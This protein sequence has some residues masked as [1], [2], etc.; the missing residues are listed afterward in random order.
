[1]ILIFVG[2]YLLARRSPFQRTPFDLLLVLFLFMALVGV[3]AAYNR[4][5]ALDKLWMLLLAISLYYAIASQ[6]QTASGY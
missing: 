2:I 1:M 5:I 6:L 4:E 3:W